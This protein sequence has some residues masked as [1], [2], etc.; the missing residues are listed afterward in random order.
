MRT[1]L[2]C[3][4]ILAVAALLVVAL[5]SARTED[6]NNNAVL[7]GRRI[8]LYWPSDGQ[9]YP[10]LITEYH[11]DSEEHTVQFDNGDVDQFRL[12]DTE[13]EWLLKDND[14]VVPRRALN[15]L[16]PLEPNELVPLSFADNGET[17]TPYAARLGL[18]PQLRT[19]LLGYC[20]RI[21]MTDLFRE[22]T[23]GDKAIQPGSEQE[24]VILG[25]QNW[26]AIRPE[27][28]WNSNMYWVEP[29]DDNAQED[30]LSALAEAGFDAVLDAV[31]RYYALETM[32]CYSLSFVAV[33]HATDESF[34]HFDFQDTGGKGFNIIVPL[35]LVPGSVP[36]LEMQDVDGN[37]QQI[38]YEYNVAV[39]VGDDNH[40][41]TS[42]VDYQQPGEMRMA[43]T[44]YC[45]DITADNVEFFLREYTPHEPVLDAN[46]LLQRRGLH[47]G[48]GKRLPRWNN[49][50]PSEEL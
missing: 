35:I 40:H 21:G 15:P 30:F 3:T 26:Y 23:S 32:T 19:S 36:E 7:V 9:R 37:L 22:L 34:L 42:P 4:S 46:D 49:D 13:F 44:I 28:H 33:T 1:L 24:K 31:G 12:D 25:R 47:W 43:A 14:F 50:A 38:P 48:G 11:P 10:G 5:P 27:K 6:E 2:F 29:M 16:G 39:V 20:D 8:S 17:I 18:S 41:R 45:A